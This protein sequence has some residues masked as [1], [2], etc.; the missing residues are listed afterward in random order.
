MLEI[1]ILISCYVRN[2]IFGGI[3][4]VKGCGGYKAKLRECFKFY[5]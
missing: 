4:G 5:F 2:E 1:E 3:G